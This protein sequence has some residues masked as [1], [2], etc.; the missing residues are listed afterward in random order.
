MYS[1]VLDAM[2]ILVCCTVIDAPV[3]V[4]TNVSMR[5]GCIRGKSSLLCQLPDCDRDLVGKLGVGGQHPDHGRDDDPLGCGRRSLVRERSA[6]AH[7][8]TRQAV[9]KTDFGGSYQN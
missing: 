9:V 4:V 5:G 8:E 6:N 2:D 3:N 1:V 7:G